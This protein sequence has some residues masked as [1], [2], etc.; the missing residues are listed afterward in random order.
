VFFKAPRG[1]PGHDLK[2]AQFNDPFGQEPRGPAQKSFRG[3]TASQRDDA[4]F[5]VASN[6]R[7]IRCFRPLEFQGVFK[8]VSEWYLK[9]SVRL[10]RLEC[11][12]ATSYWG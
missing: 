7:G 12:G 8:P 10:P 4:G 9:Q 1:F 2:D 5:N 6:H 11:A 3:L